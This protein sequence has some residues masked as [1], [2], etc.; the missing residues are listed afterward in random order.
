MIT[1]GRFTLDVTRASAFVGYVDPMGH[2]AAWLEYSPA[3][4]W[5]WVEAGWRSSR[6]PIT[7]EEARLAYHPPARL[8]RSATEALSEAEVSA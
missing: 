5:S 2:T 7:K 6:T 1:I 4:G 8:M 3:E